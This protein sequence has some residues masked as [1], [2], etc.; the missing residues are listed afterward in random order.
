MSVW[1]PKI[2]KRIVSNKNWR[3]FK[4]VDQFWIFTMY[5]KFLVPIVNDTDLDGNFKD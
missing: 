5:E 2:D 4:N 1:S 3:F